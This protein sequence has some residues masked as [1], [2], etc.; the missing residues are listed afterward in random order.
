[1]FLSPY[2]SFKGIDCRNYFIMITTTDKDDIVEVGVPYKTNLTMENSFH[3]TE[4][5]ETPDP[6]ELNLTLVDENRV[7]LKWTNEYFQNIK[8]W[9]ISDDFEEF[10]SYDNPEYVYY[11]KCISIVKNFTYGKEGWITTTFQ[12]LNHYAYKK[13]CIDKLV[14]G[15]EYIEINNITKKDYEPKIIINN[16]GTENKTIRIN[17]MLLKDIKNNENVTIDN[18]MCTI[19]GDMTGNLLSNSN[20]NW[21]LLKPGINKILVEGS[22]FINILCEFPVII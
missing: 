6:I 5:D 22:M 16:L 1:M 20:R 2:F 13:L 11:F 7:P 19:Y 4:E 8:D 17:N 9:L 3:Y 18:Y 12:P 10:V 21:I 15:K 14:D